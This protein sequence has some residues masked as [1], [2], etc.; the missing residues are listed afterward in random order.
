MDRGI[1][2]EPIE[3]EE[4]DEISILKEEL[5][6]L[7]VKSSLIIHTGKPTLLCSVWTRKSYNPNSFLAQLKSIWKAR[8]K[9]EIQVTGQNLFLIL[10]EEEEDLE[11]IL[12]VGPCPPEYERKDLIHAIGSTFGGVSRSESKRDFC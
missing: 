8:K 5:V 12:E 6:Q 11:T 3:R 7:S 1:T 10:F 2:G 4:R 9:F